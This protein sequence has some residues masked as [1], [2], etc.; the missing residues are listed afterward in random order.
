GQSL[1]YRELNRR[2]NRL[3]HHLRRLGVGAEDR[4]AFCLERSSDLWV[5]VLA[6][7]KSGGTYVPL[8]L[9]HPRERLAYV[10][11]DTGATVLLTESR[12][13]D[14][15]EGLPLASAAVVLLDQEP[16]ELA[17]ASAENPEPLP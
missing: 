15:L 1:T 5:A 4:V 7:M 12:G 13:V 11:S 9:R 3:A 14:G 2:A 6:V 8:D 17:A 16:A 10:L